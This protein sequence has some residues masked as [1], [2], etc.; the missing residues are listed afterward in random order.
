MQFPVR[1]NINTCVCVYIKFIVYVCV[2][3]VRVRCTL[4][5]NVWKKK[6]KNKMSEKESEV[7]PVTWPMKPTDRARTGGE[8]LYRCGRSFVVVLNA[9][10]NLLG[11]FIAPTISTIG[12][13]A[14]L[15]Y[16]LHVYAYTYTSNITFITSVIY[17]HMRYFATKCT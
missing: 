7:R 15:L 14:A 3:V 16:M 11:Q 9:F 17:S 5:S 4:W 12:S 10:E 2:C 1:W 13:D 8:P 6:L